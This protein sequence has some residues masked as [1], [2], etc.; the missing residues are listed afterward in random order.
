MSDKGREFIRKPSCQPARSQ[1]EADRKSARAACAR[2]PQQ[3]H[4]IDTVVVFRNGLR[5]AILGAHCERPDAA[6]TAG[7][8]AYAPDE[9]EGGERVVEAVLA[10]A[11]LQPL[12]VG[13]LFCCV[14]GEY[15]AF[16]S[17]DY[18]DQ[19]AVLKAAEELPPSFWH[20][21]APYAAPDQTA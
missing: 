1:E 12:D 21:A 15:R 11:E 10:T 16:L 13:A 6:C 9:P 4:E 2:C 20:Q 5:L 17:Y 18:P 14:P 3:K 7:M 19:A 8:L